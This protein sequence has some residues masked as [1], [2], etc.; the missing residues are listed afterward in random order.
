MAWM[1]SN[2]ERLLEYLKRVTADLRQARGRLKEVEEKDQEP[3]AVVGMGCRYPGG[4]RSP[5]DLWRLVADGTD[6]I[7]EFPGDR[8]WD[9]DLYHP[10][11]GTPGKCYTR[12]GGF[13]YD[14]G[15]FDPGFFGISPREA[16]SMD[17]QQRLLLETAWETVERAGIDPVSLRGSRTGVFVGSGYQDYATQ[18]LSVATDSDGYLGTGNS[19]SVLSGR[20]AYT[21]G[22]EGPTVTVDTACSS[23]LVALHLAAQALRQ[24]ECTMAL[25]GGVMVMATSTAFA[26]FA[27]QRGLAADGRCKAFADAADGTGWSEGV[28]M[29]VLERLSDAQRNGH[30][31]LAVIRSTAINSDGA[32]NGLTAPNGPS[33]Q[34][35]IKQALT[36]A[37]LSPAQVDAVEGHG[38][39]TVLGD[40]IEA[41]A[42]I[43]TYGQDRPADRPL[44]LGSL[45]SNIGHAQAAAG[46]GGVI[47]MI[48]AIRNGVLPRT[49]HVDQPSSHVDWSAGAVRLLTEAQ[50]WPSVDRPRRAG[51]SSFGVSGTNAHVI[52]EQAPAI[53]AETM[54]EAVEPALLPWVLSGHTDAALRAQAARLLSFV[55]THSSVDIGLSL[56]TTRSA[57]EARAVVIGSSREE[58]LDGL[59]TLADGSTAPRVVA[60]HRVGGR[61][62][63]VFSGQGSQR[64]GMGQELFEAYPVFA[65]AF[66]EVVQY[67]T[68]D[69]KS[70][71]L[72]QTGNAQ[73]AL[74]ALE[75][76]LFRL[77][78]SWGVRPDVVA[79]HSI[80]E[81][82]AAHVAGALSLEDAVTLVN[83]RAR[84]MQALP[85]G[86]AMVAIQATEE[87]VTPHLSGQVGIAA[88][89][90]PTSVVISGAEDAVTRAATIFSEQG[91]KTS[92]LKVSHAFHSPLMEPMLEEFAA[93]L[94][95]IEFQVPAIPIVSTLTGSLVERYSVEYWVQHVR[96]SVRFADGV[97]TMHAE[98]V[99]TFVEIGPGGVLSAM[100]QGV[101]D[102]VV[103]VPVL[104]ADRGEAEAAVT[105]LASLHAHGVSV[106]WSA[107]FPGAKQ[108][109]LPT[110]AFQRERY[111]LDIPVQAG[112]ASGLGLAS[113]NHPL[114][115][116]A[117]ALPGAGHVLTGRVSLRTHPW[118]ADHAMNGRV[119]VPGA[120]LVEMAVRAGD[121]VGC[122]TVEELTLAEPMA[123]PERGARQ[124]RLTVS[125]ADESGHR[126]ITIH[127]RAEDAATDEPWS[128]HAVGSLAP[129]AADPGFDLSEWPPAGAEAVDLEGFYERLTGSG[130]GYGPVFQGLSAAYRVGSD[131]YAEVRLPEGAGK[132]A[133]VFGLHPALLDAVLHGL[134]LLPEAT[135]DG[136][137]QVPFSW[138]Q[139]ALHASGATAVRA[140]LTTA[141][142]DAVTLELADETGAPVARVESLA[143]R[144]LS[145]D[146]RR[147]SESLYRIDWVPVEPGATAPEDFVVAEIAPLSTEDSATGI[148]KRVNHALTLAQAWLDD[149]DSGQLVFLTRA[150]I[151]VES[152]DLAGAAV[153]GLI[154]SA[155]A[156]NPGRFVLLDSDVSDRAAI[157]EALS[158]GEDQIVLREGKALVPRLARASGGAS[159]IPPPGSRPWCLTSGGSALDALALSPAPHAERPL[160]AGEVRVEVRAAGL[161]FRDVL[162]AL[163]M[164]PEPGQM[165]LEG[166]GVVVEVG[167][168][169][170]D[171]NVG[172]AVLGLFHGSFGPVATADRRMI[173]VKP[174]HWSF[175]QAAAAPIV[176]LTA[177][178]SLID[179]A[180]LQSGERVLIHAAAGGVGIAAVQLAKHLGAEV[181]ATA[182]LG[183]HDTVRGLGVADD[184]IA[185]SRTL[186]FEQEFLGVTSGAGVDVVLDSLAREFVDA[187]LRLLPR[188]GRFVEMGKTDVRSPE[189]V[190]ADHPG[191][192]YQAFDLMEAGPERIGEMLAEVLALFERGV[193]TPPPVSTWDIRRAPEAFRHL[194]RA[195]H[196]GKVVLTMPKQ[197]DRDGTVLV[198][199]GTGGL[200]QLVAKHLVTERGVRNLLLTSRRGI[201]A[202]GAAS[203]RDE[204]AELG[205]D[206]TIAACDVSDR[207]AL[208]ALI[209]QHP[210]T[211]VV[212]TAGVLD[213]GV[214]TAL[215]PERV[216]TVLG[217]KVDAA[218]HLH[219]L[220]GDVA[221]FVLFSSA[222][223]IFGTPGQ[224]NYAAA[225]SALD[226]L[227]AQRRANGLTA[228]SLAWGVWANGMASTVDSG[229]SRGGFV[230]LSN[231]D[232][233]ELFGLASTVDDA[234]LVPMMLDF[235]DLRQA[236]TVPPLLRGLVRGASRRAAKSAA[237]VGSGLAQRLAALSESDRSDL[238]LEVVRAETAAVLGHS[239]ADAVS[240]GQAFKDMG[241]DSLTAV[242]LRN[243][244]QAA[245]SVRLPATLVFDYPNA[246]VLAR[247]LLSE[248]L[249]AVTEVTVQAAVAVDEPIAIVGMSCRYPGGIR[250][251]EDL[252]QL[253]ISGGDGVSGFPEDRGWDV[254]GLFDPDSARKGTSY[255]REGGFLGDAAQFDPAFFGISPREAL[256]MDPQQRLLLEGTWEAFERAGIDPGSVRG[257][258]TGVFVGMAYLGYGAGVQDAPEDV[259]GH[260]LTGSAASVVSGRVA[261]TFGLEGPAIT[262]DTACSSSLV[263][264]HMAIQSLRG[265]ECDMA[266]AGGV[267]VMAS[268]GMFVEFS[269]QR[270]L[271]VDG[272]CKSFAEGADGTGWG[273][274]VGL[275]LVERLSEAERLGHNVLAVVRGSAINSDG[276]SNGLTAPNGPSQQRVIRQALASAGLQPSQVHAVEAH[277]TGTRLGDPI[278]AQA[279][280]A[281]YGQDRDEPLLLG[282]LKSNIGHTQSAAG[283]G[284]V[285]KMVMALRHGVLPPTLHVDAPTSQVDWSE[286]NIRLLT[287]A[288]DW[289]STGEPRRAAVSSFGISGTNAHTIIE[290]APVAAAAV[291]PGDAVVPWVLSGKSDAAVRAQASRLLS[292]VDDQHPVDVAFSLATARAALDYRTA[293]VGQDRA[294]LLAGLRG[295]VAGSESI[296]RAGGGKTAF[297]FS[298]QGSQRVGMGQEL[299]EAYP[300]FADAFTEVVQYLTVDV[301]SPDL[302]Q[303]GNAQPALFAIEVA[304]FRLLESWGVRP[305]V[306]A[307]H[308]IGEIAAAHVAGVLSL[309]DAAVLVSARARLMQALPSGGAMV[310][311][312]ASEEEVLPLLT[313]GVGIAAINGPTSVVLS[314]E[315]EAVLGVVAQFS[316]RKTSRLKVSHAFHSPLMEPMLAEFAAVLSGIEFRAPGIPIVSTLTGSLVERYSVE[317]WVRHVRD[318]VRFADGVQALRAQGVTR[319]VEVGPGG[320]LSAMVQGCVDDAV[321][322]PVLRADRVEPQ[323][324]MTALGQ[325]HGH[326]VPVD[327]KTVLN[328]GR[329][330][331]LPTYAFQHERF[332]LAPSAPAADPVDAEFWDVVEREDLESLATT[333]DVPADHL[334]TVLPGLAAWRRLRHGQSEVDTWTYRETWKPL[335][336]LVSAGL[337][338]NWLLAVTEEDERSALLAKE[339]GFTTIRVTTREDL[340]AKLTGAVDGVLALVDTV[341]ALVLTQALGD[342]EVEAPLW[343]ATTGAVAVDSVDQVRNPEQTQLWG[344]GRT[345]AL[346]H[347]ARWGGLVDLPEVLDARI[348]QR[349]AEVL[350]QSTEDQLAVRASG[351]FGRR[352][353]HAPARRAARE[354]TPRGTVL[355]TGGTGALGGHVAK[356][357][358]SAGAE[359]LILTSRRGPDAPGALE[360]TAELENLGARVTV[361][362][363]DVADRDAVRALLD[364]HD[365]NA[366]VHTAG[367]ADS[368]LLAE[369]STAA[370]TNAL[371]AKVDGAVHLDELLGDKELDAFVLFSSIAGVWGSGGQ[372]AYA[373][374]NAFL[375]GLARQRRARGLTATA[376]AWGPWAD[377]GM[378]A[379]GD[380]EERLRRRGLTAMPAAS[381][382]T[383][384]RRALDRDETAV[385]VAEVDW[386]RFIGPFT[387]SRP[388]P[389]L[390]DLP[391]VRAALTADAPT[392]LGAGAS[393]LVTRLAGLS[394]DDQTAV[395]VDLVRAHAASV[396][397]HTGV[398][399]VEAGLRFK[400]LGFD[401][402]TAVELR[403]R[404]NAETGLA[405]PPTLVFDHPTANDLATHLRAELTGAGAVQDAEVSSVITD[406]EPIAIVGMACRYPGGVRSPEELWELVRSGADAISEFPGNRGWDLEGLYHPDP[407]HSGTTYTTQG[408]FLHDAPEFDSAFFGISPREAIAMDPQ[409]RLLLE[410]AWETFERAGVQPETVR[411]S[412][413]GVFVGN[414]YQDYVGRPITVPEGVEGYLP[415][416]NT[417]SVLSGRIS[418]TFG[419]QGPSVTVDTACSASLVAIHLAAQALRKGECDLA[420]AGG[421]MVMSSPSAFTTSSKQ[422]AL[423][424]DG[425]C[426]AFADSA[427]GTGFAEGV[428]MILV[429]RLS[430]ARRNGHQVLAIVRSSAVNSDGASNGLTAPSGAAQRRVIRQA[431]ANGGLQPSEVDAVEAHGTGT[432]LGDPIE[433]QALLATYGRDREQPLHIGSLKSNIGHTQG[434]AGVGGVIKMVMAIR[435]GVLPKTLHVDE[436]STS[437]DW[438][439]GNVRVLTEAVEWPEVDRPRRAGVSSFGMSGTNAHVI[440]EQAQETPVLTTVERPEQNV[441][442]LVSG[443]STGALSAQARRIQSFVDSNP[444]IDIA[445]IAFSLVTKRTAF[446]NRAVVVGGDR[447]ELLRGLAALG[448]K[449]PAGNLVQGFASSPGKVAFVFPGHGSQWAEMAKELLETSPVFAAKAH[450]CA[451]AFKPYVD[452]SVLD[453]LRA[454]PGV[455]DLDRVDI[456]QPVLFTVMV[457]LAE[458]WRSHGVTPAAVIGHSQ[459]EVAAAHFAGALSLEDAARIVALRIR[460][461]MKLV[462]KGAMLAVASPADEI[463]RRLERFG[464]QLSVAAINGPAALTVSGSPEAVDELLTELKADGFR[465][466]KVRGANGAG[467]SAQIEVLREELLEALAP[468]SPLASDIPFYST[469]TGD[470]IDTTELNAQYWYRNARESVLFEPTV[471]KLLEDGFGAFVE[472]SSHPLL[473]SAVQEIADDAG[474]TVVVGGSLRRDEGGL[475]RFLL[476]AADLHVNGV[477]VDWAAVT[478]GAVAVDLPTYPFQRQ[479]YWLENAAPVETDPA[480]AE[481]WSLVE[482]DDLQGLASAV[483]GDEELIKPVLPLLSAWRKQSR[484][485]STM[486]DWRY[487]IAWR[488]VPEDDLAVITEPVLVVVPAG[489]D[490]DWVV[491]NMTTVELPLE[492]DRQEAAAKLAEAIG[493]QQPARVLSLLGLAEGQHPEHP[494]LSTGLALSL[495]L[496]QAL[497]DLDVS[498]PLWCATRGAVSI[499]RSDAVFNPTQ[500]QLWGFGRVAALEHSA[501]WGGLVDLP[502]VPDERVLRRLAQVI[503]QS[504]EDQLAVR[505]SGMFARRMVR[506]GTTATG[507]WT[508]RG[509]VLITG[510][511]GGV[512]RHLATWLAGAGVEHLVLTSRRGLDAPGAPELKAELEKTGVKV[513]IAACDIADKLA[514]AKLL[515]ENPVNAV[516]H[517]AG[518]ARSSLLSQAD[519]AEFAE[520]AASKV[521]GAI[522]LDDLL[523]DTELD[524]FVL[525]ASG[526]GVWG[527][528]GQASYAAANAFLDG[529]AQWRRARGRT[530]TSIAWGGWDG[531]GM[532]DD[533]VRERGEK[534]GLGAMAPELAIKALRQA[535]EHG[536]TALTVAPIDWTRFHP[537]FTVGRPSPLLSELPEVRELSTVEEEAPTGEATITSE[538]AG[539]SPEEQEQRLLELVRAQS[540]VVLGYASAEDVQAAQPFLELGFDSLTAIDLRKRLSTAIGV[541]LPA[542]LAFDHPTPAKL[543]AHLRSLLGESTPTE[544]PTDML[545]QL[546]QRA[547]ERGEVM[548]AMGMLMQA[549]AFRS[550]FDDPAKLDA[551]PEPVRFSQGDGDA[552]IC[553][554]PY[555]VPAGAHQYARFAATFRGE[556]DVWALPHPGFGEGE[557]LPSTMDALLRLHAETVL[558]CAGDK[559][560]VLLGYSSGGWIAHGVA[561]HLE[562]MGVK[563]RAVVM[564]DSFSRKAPVNLTVLGAMANEQAVRLEF[565]TAGG[566]QLTAMG[567]Y[568][569]LLQEWEVPEIQAPTLLVRAGEATLRDCAEGDGR[570]APPEH[571]LETVEVPGNHYTMLEDHAG[572][573]AEAVQTWLTPHTT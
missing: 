243:R 387:L 551:R 217:P 367:V 265:G 465:A 391:E 22:L 487:R 249:G 9:E 405:L 324:I 197:L 563:P 20:L 549:A 83:A 181:F 321:A 431:L 534:R 168:G 186:D 282:S 326:G 5:E 339:L 316:D 439:A 351:I 161:N 501:R 27:R 256:A 187:S 228:H 283:V 314:G 361:A 446:D 259:G 59:R 91:R 211:G 507:E 64:V 229:R 315:E 561:A 317:Y 26:E 44:W 247:F 177:Y 142:Q 227:A 132:D 376:I 364:E 99:R 29:L 17:P 546:Y 55:D 560:I 208:A 307:G 116:A 48:M 547:T 260:L 543:A 449:E 433:A 288:V 535:V 153:W 213:D 524:A 19:A 182:S 531:G 171:L 159:L 322:V 234:V 490:Q 36:N 536:E 369:T 2:E 308:S 392:G 301:K 294:E 81:I 263:A 363:C 24:H 571:V 300:V 383:A 88:V 46:V 462:G 13:L 539:L 320:V 61:V 250:S 422:R 372:A 509:T 377:G 164:Y 196:I 219:E 73:P 411:G 85:T 482:G 530:A 144:T 485:K 38:T 163:G 267:A 257:S 223:G 459:G 272:R 572:T 540:A 172:D 486:D 285:I 404:I 175:E 298:G 318:S 355:I 111:W 352:L 124:L 564:V 150:A 496:V 458:L 284:G 51:V 201:D 68:A 497:G 160:G 11:P 121:E 388:S 573:T 500:T 63:F 198:T 94:V 220:V 179:L 18:A 346:E 76:A 416:G 552:L 117:V 514:L 53:E 67:L 4:V 529:L 77:L 248:L 461:L 45:K 241:F 158:T 362:A 15:E 368:G 521:T 109:D 445:D 331:D 113:A 409:Q 96:D 342:A 349:L 565:M 183:K 370:F 466:R 151:N 72:D 303:T 262:V 379:D 302:D 254:D 8:G 7:G 79:G 148:R 506:A 141:G 180:G 562:D 127:S 176:Y 3:I 334:S 566:E 204:L 390:G 178:Y 470:R 420:L 69:V 209:A 319:F 118:L 328:G 421:V 299:F 430:D 25:A 505:E 423:A 471:R 442:W 49:L 75:V 417:A 281:T 278:E 554:T 354:W 58:L 101:L 37:G 371:A 345:A 147:L 323:A 515:A 475:R 428:G 474:S 464:D 240:A 273:E 401:S 56:A 244:L 412:E 432:Q 66:T 135:V 10:D 35:V 492:A 356:W 41:Q 126:D 40:P 239:G 481:F 541:N 12:H 120:A 194:S 452:W 74:F 202:P 238:V 119:L 476:S 280:L 526:A 264:L 550:T 125:E 224:G 184:H 103:A 347:P 463:A 419:L 115:S 448:E 193:L 453:V 139:V 112:D 403:N 212:H 80:G 271:A 152:P 52:V 274:G 156:E 380:D 203:L 32:S 480:S 162:I 527:S 43:A 199:G 520:A 502:A 276:A 443:K 348:A 396:L 189:V 6:A 270:G 205:A 292:F 57:L 408:G 479:R 494:T 293:V 325:L 555:V 105:A 469:V 460:S 436:P 382:I 456:A 510:G 440:I 252:W 255:T 110:Y 236:P 516:L 426:K 78:E 89:N 519:F 309:P 570:A 16:I 279:L 400:E 188:G 218:L 123:L 50:P 170:T 237:V 511:T 42:L 399:A 378:V 468:V 21:F 330:I 107:F 344:F 65:D 434:A 90:G 167:E 413:T 28:G 528:G 523:A 333:L 231:E 275:L 130:Y 548:A 192:A 341:G 414:G 385:T 415:T 221:M 214:L 146:D 457:S 155:Q 429:E 373:A 108:I 538:L 30:N 157:A 545:V 517:A 235:G 427:D 569:R 269:R 327:W 313:D 106:D 418:Y 122:G 343:C 54:V 568:E 60:G 397:G 360:L 173:A 166:A 296:L 216:D 447:E 47:K 522:N 138:S 338:G 398:G 337:S 406:D 556:R 291:E 335:T 207:D 512:G 246:T 185:N 365:V 82:A 366:V 190:A 513:T 286:G 98:E 84:L 450:A 473:V 154:R 136:P 305:D 311:V 222:S 455:P 340:A 114:L 266:L 23:S 425:R 102:D 232:G 395:L 336:G 410:T 137:A 87:E 533:A 503:G 553:F 393:A 467:H 261:Y 304:L 149:A 268:P 357:L 493:G 93:V 206:V 134:S 131:V 389:L 225:N 92:R 478:P 306:L 100:V 242:E 251:P 143:M 165:G 558:E 451:E 86:G 438:S 200:G 384:L 1:S 381:A 504:T 499:G 95:G 297:V 97:R 31:V 329:T 253:V 245:T 129:N 191:V 195:Q 435:N 567:G 295:V 169:V 312:Q 33:Q 258:R 358:A 544:R 71:D 233:V 488:P 407:E 34:R 386:E 14:A 140:R 133:A 437:I 542:G 332:W 145:L 491:P 424:V 532:V 70:P 215:T 559:P 350:G 394:E 290:E 310:A 374:G 289:P 104:R 353:A 454:E 525:F 375:D 287:E 495:V 226:A 230:P 508:P 489:A 128:L 359:H 277:G 39:G 441:A 477:R 498:A 484:Q 537:A 174:E 557:L 62:G 402:L 518:T 210:L 483:G 472:S 444:E